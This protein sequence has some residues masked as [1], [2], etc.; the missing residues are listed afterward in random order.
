[1][2][3][4]EIDQRDI[5]ETLAPI[6]HDKADTARKAMNRLSICMQHAAALGLE[7][8]LQATEK[9]KALLGKQRH[10]AKNVPAMRGQDVPAFYQS[11]DDSTSQLALRLLI[12]TALRSK[13]I[14]FA[15]LDQIE[16]NVWTVPAEM[17]KGRKDSTSEF[18]VPLSSEALRVIEQAAKFE[19][20][21]FLF[22]NVRRGVIS[23]ATM[24]RFME[25][26]GLEARPHGFRSSFRTW[27]AETTDT[28]WE[29]AEMCLGHSVGSGVERAYKRTDFLD[30]RAGLMERW[31]SYLAKKS[32]GT[33]HVMD[34]LNA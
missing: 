8:D 3:V 33:H 12:L 21:G 11:L 16:G 1:M 18:R 10:T 13:P 17:M 20:D 26:A 23:D 19:R 29:I 15:R 22:P 6:W 34:E 30:Q 14:R 2:P 7:V 4:S 27:C 31:A 5:R 9:A 24:S 25:R 32:V 28:P